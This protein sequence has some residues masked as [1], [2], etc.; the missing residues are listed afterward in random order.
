MVNSV[1]PGQTAHSVHL[2]WVYTF[3][4]IIIIVA[5]QNHVHHFDAND[6]HGLMRR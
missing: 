3:S 1:D 2:I 5:L 6:P 4:D